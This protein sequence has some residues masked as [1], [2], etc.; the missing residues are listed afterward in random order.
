MNHDLTTNEELKLLRL[1]EGY[2]MKQLET[3]EIAAQL[4][5]SEGELLINSILEK[6]AFNQ[7]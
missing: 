3:K 6:L 2:G 5:Y 4:G 1:V 7:F